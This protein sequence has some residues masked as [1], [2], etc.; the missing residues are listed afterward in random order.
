MPATWI[1]TLFEKLQT[2]HTEP[3]VVRRSPDG[4]GLLIHRRDG[5]IAERAVGPREGK[6]A[7]HF[8]TPK[9]LADFLNSRQKDK[10]HDVDILVGDSKITAHCAP[11]DLCGDVLEHGY[12]LDP[13]YRP[14][15]EAFIQSGK[16]GL[17]QKDMIRLIRASKLALTE[18]QAQEWLAALGVL[19]VVS[20]GHIESAVDELGFTRVA[21]GDQQREISTKIP[22]QIFVTCPFF[23]GIVDERGVPHRYG[24]EVLVEFEPDEL[25]FRLTFPGRD[26]L[27][28]RAVEDIAAMVR[29]ELLEDFL[30]VR[31]ESAIVEVPA[32]DLVE[33]EV[34]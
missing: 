14:W 2:L 26:L 32:F 30:V 9:A 17:S 24:F 27:R 11:S 31:G 6:R 28:A 21:G 33:G 3:V 19:R 16:G 5:Y 29:R 20:R 8:A 13:E 7:H 15:E 25:S 1:Q 10:P 4:D 22:P 34:A 23:E 18:E 12:R